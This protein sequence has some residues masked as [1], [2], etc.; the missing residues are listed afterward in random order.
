MKS[1]AS[2]R[3]L[4]LASQTSTSIF[5]D[6][7]D[8][9]AAER[10]ESVLH[11]FEDGET[12]HWARRLGGP[13]YLGNALALGGDGQSY[14]AGRFGW[15]DTEEDAKGGRLTRF[16]ADGTKGQSVEFA[17]GNRNGLTHVAVDTKG[18]VWVG[19]AW[20]TAFDFSGKSYAPPTD[21]GQFVLRK[22]GF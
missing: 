19:G 22:K 2:G 14:V 8:T 10:S 5:L 12:V 1:T 3:L 20:E 18:G 13:D 9:F 15:L 16:A 7:T 11:D 6:H 4:L 21:G 17:T